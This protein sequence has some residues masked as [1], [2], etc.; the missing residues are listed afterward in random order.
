MMQNLYLLSTDMPLLKEAW[1]MLQPLFGL[2]QGNQRSDWPVLVSRM[3]FEG[4]STQLS[5]QTNLAEEA[6]S[7]AVGHSEHFLWP[8]QRRTEK[9]FTCTYML[10]FF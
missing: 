8:P 5:A 9:E 2:T 4:L 10:T 1:N 7:D 6:L 3:P